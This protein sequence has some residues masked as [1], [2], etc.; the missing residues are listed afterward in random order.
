LADLKARF[1]YQPTLII[2]GERTGEGETPFGLVEVKNRGIVRVH[3]V[4]S[5]SAAHTALVKGVTAFEKVFALERAMRTALREPTDPHWKSSFQVSY[6]LGGENYNFNTSAKEVVAGFEMRPA[7]TD[8]LTRVMA[9]LER[10]AEEYDLEVDVLNGE[11]SVITDPDDPAVRPLIEAVAAVNGVSTEAVVGPGKLPGS[12]ARFAPAGCAAVV[13][14]QAG[15][16]PHTS[17]EAHYIPSI[18]PFYAVLARLFA[19]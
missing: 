7:E 9:A 11:P 10:T 1:G 2:A 6:V 18:E 3:T 14:G 4:A 15:V 5:G 8:D 17:F 19:S 13:W 16:G 12:Q